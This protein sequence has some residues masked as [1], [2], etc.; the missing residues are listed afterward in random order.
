MHRHRL[1]IR[2]A[3]L[4]APLAL[5]LAGCATPPP[6]DPVA[7]AVESLAEQSRSTYRV[8]AASFSLDEHCRNGSVDV[9]V[10]ESSYRSGPGGP[11]RT[12]LVGVWAYVVDTCSVSEW[13]VLFSASGWRTVPARDFHMTSNLGS[14]RLTTS[15]DLHD[16]TAD[17]TYPIDVD[18][19]WVG[20]GD[21]WKTRDRHHG[22]Y[23][24]T[25]YRSHSSAS[26]RSA[27]AFA[28]LPLTAF[29]ISESLHGSGWMVTS[30]GS[31]IETESGRKRRSPPQI[32][33]LAAYPNAIFPGGSAQIYWWVSSS[34]PVTLH[35]D[36]VG[37]VSGTD[38]T[39]VAPTET[40]TYTL[41][42]T[43][44]WGSSSAAVTIHVVPPP[45]DD[46]FEP[47]ETSGVA[48]ELTLGVLRELTLTTG[49]V[50]WFTFDL[51]EAA[52]VRIVLNTTY[53]PI[54]PLAT[55]FGD[56]LEPIAQDLYWNEVALA[57]GRYYVAVT[58]YPDYEYLGHHWET[59]F[60]TLEISVMAPTLPDAY[61]PNDTPSTARPIGLHEPSE[62]LTIT[63]QDV[64]WFS[65][66]LTTAATVVA[67]VDA[68]VLGST[69]DSYLGI[70]D[71]NLVIIGVNDD[72]ELLDSRI[73]AYLVAGDY[74]IAVTGFPDS[75]FDG[76]HR[77]VG[78]YYLSVGVEP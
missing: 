25:K 7:T 32:D 33:Y 42:A 49:D 75:D 45:E 2:L 23:G 48:R 37:D 51:L 22:S 50:D 53:P 46:A 36:G 72:H 60:Y 15:I 16:W 41:T 34:D 8:A 65:F 38:S 47:N 28:S 29:G 64:D 10:D 9:Y 56:D 31:S 55:L 67:D 5:V 63:P 66:T 12:T 77:Q 19:D 6:P 76:S 70:F 62:E 27:E 17:A 78:F 74:F 54:Q 26:G 73:E 35:I 68:M 30:T 71:A 1:R 52:T 11:Q 40:T 58:G 20:V 14:A 69:L 4:L 13:D 57:A 61:E 39:P 18:V 44:R 59:G 3:S 24:E 43:N 21:A